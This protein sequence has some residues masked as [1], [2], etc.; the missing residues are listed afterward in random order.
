MSTTGE[1]KKDILNAILR[2]ETRIHVDHPQGKR[3]FDEVLEEHPEAQFYIK[4]IRFQVFSGLGEGTRLILSY[5]NTDIPPEVI[6]KVDTQDEMERILHACIERYL[7]V[8]VLCVPKSINTSKVYNDF[9]V[10]YDGFY[11]N[12]VGLECTTQA[13]TLSREKFAIFRFQYRIGR[14]KL[15]MMER[16]VDDEVERLGKILFSKDMLPETKAYVAHNYLAQT[17][18]YWLKEEANPLEKSYMQSAYGALINHKCVCQGYAEAYKRF[19]DSQGIICYVVCGKIRGSEENHAW[20]VISFDGKIFYHVDVTWD[21][22][23]ASRASWN[24]FC[25]SDAQIAPTRIWTRKSGVICSSEEDILSIARKE[26]SRK[27]RIY[28]AQ[29]LDSKYF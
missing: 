10:E 2:F 1:T 8:T 29:G 22:N 23:H 13:F 14:V 19:M 24:Y 16:A 27:R 9:M 12:L 28:H 11:S 4:S 15:S 26:I 21:V 17:V 20:N 25:K 3:L 6:K 7:P 18:E 5:T